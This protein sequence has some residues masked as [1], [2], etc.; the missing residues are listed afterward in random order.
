MANIVFS[1][2]DSSPH[3]TYSLKIFSKKEREKGILT[4]EFFSEQS[5]EQSI[6]Q[7][8]ERANRCTS[9]Y[10]IQ[11]L[12]VSVFPEYTTT[13]R[14]GHISTRSPKLPHLKTPEPRM[15]KLTADWE[16]QTADMFQRIWWKNRSDYGIIQLDV[17]TK[18]VTT[19][20]AARARCWPLS[21]HW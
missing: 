2:H 7:G 10:L 18:P 13:N 17:E 21:L 4:S 20:T 3:S 19:H 14:C 1:T 16:I 9:R 15:P 6:K 8:H 12:Y 5:L 11:L